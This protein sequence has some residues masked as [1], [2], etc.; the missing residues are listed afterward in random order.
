MDASGQGS[1]VI[2]FTHDDATVR[3]DPAMETTVIPAVE[4][5]HSTSLADCKSQDSGVGDL[6]SPLAGLLHRQH[7]VA[8][9]PQILHDWVIKILVGVEFGHAGSGFVVFLEGLI[10]F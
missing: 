6:L 8:E 4:G 3:K 7:I 2:A 1:E 10:N 5:K 9:L